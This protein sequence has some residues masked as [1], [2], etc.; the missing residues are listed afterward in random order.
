SVY[1]NVIMLDCLA[2]LLSQ[3]VTL[4]NAYANT[5]KDIVIGIHQ[6]VIFENHYARST[7]RFAVYMRND[8]MLLSR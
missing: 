6:D 1:T 3:V 2:I 7:C 4:I 8:V 5:H